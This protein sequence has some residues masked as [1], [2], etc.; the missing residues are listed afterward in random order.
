MVW[1][2]PKKQSYITFLPFFSKVNKCNLNNNLYYNEI[3]MIEAILGQNQ[4][5]GLAPN[6]LNFDAFWTLAHKGQ[7]I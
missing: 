3:V 5:I 4:F 7:G 6:C 1:I 2:Q